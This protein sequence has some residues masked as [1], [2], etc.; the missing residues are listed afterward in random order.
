MTKHRLEVECHI[1]QER[2]P[3]LAFFRMV[4]LTLE[5]FPEDCVGMCLGLV[6]LVQKKVCIKL[7]EL[8]HDDITLCFHIIPCLPGIVK[9]HFGCLNYQM[10]RALLLM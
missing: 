6:S 2:L 10:A 3:S 4:Y 8:C 1:V 9:G 5:V 7:K